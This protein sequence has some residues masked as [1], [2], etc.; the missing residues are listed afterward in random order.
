MQNISRYISKI[1][2]KKIILDIKSLCFS[3]R[4]EQNDFENQSFTKQ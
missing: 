3:N 2:S 4:L 1:I